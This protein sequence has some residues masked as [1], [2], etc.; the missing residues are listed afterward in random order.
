MVAALVYQPVRRQTVMDYWPRGGAADLWRCRDG[1]VL[2]D[3]PAGT[4]KTRACL[5]KLHQA[6]IN[7]PGMRGLMVRKTFESLKGSAM[8]TFTERVQPELDGVEFFG[9]SKEKDAG[10]YY[11]NGSFVGVGGLDKA[12]KIMS[13]EFDL[14]YVV[15]ATELTENDWESITARL[16][17][18]V[19]PYQ[20]L[21]A[22]CNPDVQTHWLNQRCNAGK[23]T[24]ILSRH[25]DNPMLWDPKTGD[26]TAFGAVYMGRLNALS[27]VRK[28]RLADGEWC[29]AE[30]QVYEA[31]DAAVHLIDRDQLPEFRSYV[32]GVD[33]GYTKPGT[34]ELY[35]V[36]G[37]SDMVQV[38]EVYM[39]RKTI[40][41]W[42][43]KGKQVESQFGDVTFACDPSE[44]AYIE[45]FRQAGLNAI[46]GDNAILAG[47]NAVQER[48][49]FKDDQPPRMHFLRDALESIDPGLQEAK[50][51]TRLI[52]EIPSYV[53]SQ[54]AVGARKERP[55]DE[56]NHANDAQRYAVRY[57]DS[58]G[59]GWDDLQSGLGGWF[60]EMGVG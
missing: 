5:Q 30:G 8:V 48:L 46:P 27:G 58:G 6:A 36:T 53:W 37:D 18:G 56:Y 39:T 14:V 32:C 49:A 9:G 47:I 3:G 31:Y 52:E 44:P 25:K 12:T 33:W 54:S 4:G 55:I 19:M 1:E 45:Q 23:T 60:G 38:F 50:Q 42:I 51:P 34:F 43:V 21:I 22:D 7:Y 35:G 2:V 59:S 41:W 40:D 13:K 24:R 11:P 20:Q 29:A 16:R 17:Y 57:V 10:Y 28:R 26:W 15:E